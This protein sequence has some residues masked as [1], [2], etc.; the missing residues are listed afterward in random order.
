M[1]SSWF[2]ENNLPFVV[3]LRLLR[4]EGY[5]GVKTIQ[6]RQTIR[7]HE[8]ELC[9]G[10]QVVFFHE[11]QMVGNGV[12]VLD[13]NRVIIVSGVVYQELEADTHIQ[14]NE[15]DSVWFNNRL[16]ISFE[17]WLNHLQ[18]SDHIGTVGAF[19]GK[20]YH[21]GSAS[22]IKLDNERSGFRLG[23]SISLV[24]NQEE[25]YSFYLN[26]IHMRSIVIDNSSV[27]LTPSVSRSDAK[28]RFG[29]RHAVNA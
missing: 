13:E 8:N 27:G 1:S 25:I 24:I 16:P 14:S 29:E 3:E 15:I 23:S 2:V 12:T 17:I 7:L 9:S 5:Q 26:N 10:D 6:Q 22:S 4:G 21:A 28:Y 18:G 19:D 20:G 11:D